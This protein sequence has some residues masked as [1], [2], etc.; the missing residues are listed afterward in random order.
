MDN[1]LSKGWP[2]RRRDHYYRK[3]KKEKSMSRSK[4][5]LGGISLLFFCLIF[6]IEYGYSASQS[7]DKKWSFDFHNC[8]ISD[9]LQEISK[10]SRIDISINR[11]MNKTLVNKSYA[12]CAIK[13]IIRDLFSNENYAIGFYPNQYAPEFIQILIVGNEGSNKPVVAVRPSKNT[14][15]EM[16]DDVSDQIIETESAPVGEHKKNPFVSNKPVNRQEGSQAFFASNISSGLSNRTM[17]PEDPGAEN[18]N[19][20]LKQSHLGEDTPSPSEQQQEHTVETPPV[21][22]GFN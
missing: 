2:T 20:K 3:A 21:P 5:Y 10:K 22:P 12:H 13:E 6:S 4:K 15:V 14:N 1:F 16:A 8:S 9:A 19:L 7:D 18:T 17:K 11:A